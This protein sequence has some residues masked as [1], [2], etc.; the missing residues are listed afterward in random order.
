MEIVAPESINQ[1]IWVL[2]TVPSLVGLSLLLGVNL[3][4]TVEMK[5]QTAE[6]DC[7]ISAN[8]EW[9]ALLATSSSCS[10]E[11]ASPVLARDWRQAVWVLLTQYWAS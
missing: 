8:T 11:V 10:E 3:V 6:N 1:L 4:A 2:L 7:R 5:E 9:L